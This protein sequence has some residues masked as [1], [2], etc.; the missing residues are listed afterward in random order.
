MVKT[1][2]FLPGTFFLFPTAGIP[3]GITPCLELCLNPCG[4]GSVLRCGVS[5]V[6]S[7]LSHRLSRSAEKISRKS[8]FNNE[9]HPGVS[10]RDL[11]EVIR[12]PFTQV[13]KLT[14]TV[15]KKDHDL[16]YLDNGVIFPICCTKTNGVAAR[17]FAKTFLNSSGCQCWNMW[18]QEM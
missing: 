11:L 2:S 7:E 1:N 10:S 14:S 3:G 17:F 9:F 5:G 16:N 13:G 12:D 15:D 4:N 18:S 6:S 8:S